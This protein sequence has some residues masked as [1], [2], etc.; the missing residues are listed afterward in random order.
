MPLSGRSSYQ[1]LTGSGFRSPCT[2]SWR[3]FSVGSTPMYRLLSTELQNRSTTNRNR[4]S[5]N[6]HVRTT[7]V[8][9]IRALRLAHRTLFVSAPVGDT[10]PGNGREVTLPQAKQEGA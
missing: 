2:A 7:I 8:S 1:S 10:E 3:S 4:V 5:R 9:R 6:R